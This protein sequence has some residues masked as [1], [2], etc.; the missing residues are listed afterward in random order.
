MELWMAGKRRE[1]GEEEEEGRRGGERAGGH[2]ACRG[3][4]NRSIA[5]AE[6]VAGEGDRRKRVAVP[7]ALHDGARRPA[8]ALCKSPGAGKSNLLTVK[9]WSHLGTDLDAVQARP[10]EG[11]TQPTDDASRVSIVHWHS[12]LQ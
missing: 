12:T 4:C 6:V 10:G 1:E 5:E 8:A 7:G 11:P 9:R 2:L 3:G